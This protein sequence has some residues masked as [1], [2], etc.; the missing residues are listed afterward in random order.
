MRKM[1]GYCGIVCSN[2]PV[3]IATKMDRDAERKKVAELFTKQYRRKYK[4]EDINCDGCLSDGPRIFSYCNVCK[5][6]RC[7]K[8]KKVKNCAYCSEYPCEKL[9]ALFKK[10]PKAKDT[11]EEIRCK[12]SL[13]NETF[14]SNRNHITK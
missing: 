6:R 8:E 11:L 12:L 5:I 14:S 9:S 3:F 10:Y 4:P 7:G 13:K 1:I 2:C